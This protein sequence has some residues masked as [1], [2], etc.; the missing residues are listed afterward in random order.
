MKKI[1]TIILSAVLML[2]AFAMVGC[3][4]SKQAEDKNNSDLTGWAYIEDKGEMIIGLDDTFAP[5]GFRDEEGNL[6]GFDIDLANAV[7]EELGVK[8]TF[9][10]IDW[11]AKEM[12]LKSKRID[13]IWNG[14]SVTDD[15]ME[16]MALTDKYINNK[17]I[18]MAKDGTVKVKK[19]EDLAQYNVGTQADSSALEVLKA[20]EAYDTYADKISDYKTY[21]EA[22]MDM[23]AGRIDC[24]AVDQVLGEYKN[25]K[26]E[27]KM[28][29]CD[30][31]FGDDFYAI[32]C[33]IEDKDV[34]AKL[35]EALGAVIESGKAEEIS[36]KWFGRNI[37]ILEGYDK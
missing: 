33:R 21:D 11:D 29:V 2:G 27:K 24:I 30:Y 1:I 31:D 36:N 26:L 28:I 3:G 10:P 13:C 37:V 34:A 18:I 23:Q 14:M 12:E 20:N 8:M 7:G 25:S 17:I 4:D 5:M 16:K 35:T 9:K 19:A 22:I 32:G 6:V 15:R